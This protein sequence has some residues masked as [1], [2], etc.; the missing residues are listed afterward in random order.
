VPADRLPTRLLLG[1]GACIVG[2]GFVT[3]VL[4]H[5]G[6]DVA[7]WYL[8][9]MAPLLAAL[10]VLTWFAMRSSARAERG[11][12]GPR[13]ETPATLYLLLP[14]ERRVSAAVR[15]QSGYLAELQ[16]LL[17][18]IAEER[19]GLRITSEDARTRLGKELYE[20]LT[21]T[22]TALRAPDMTRL[23]RLV[24]ALERL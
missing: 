18:E 15:D 5:A 19:T 21:T 10:A 24:S 4:H 16:P 3:V 23:S 11:P 7:T 22:N 20:W 6:V 2:G 12:H 1:A 14:L 9:A 13:L 17:V 8:S